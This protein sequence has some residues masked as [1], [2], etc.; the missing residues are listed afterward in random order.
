MHFVLGAFPKIVGSAIMSKSTKQESIRRKI[1]VACLGNPDRGDDAL[2]AMVAHEL[3][4]R[5]PGEVALLLCTGDTFSLIDDW[6]GYDALICVDAAAPVGTPG[7]IHRIDA[8]TDELLSNIAVTSSH[9]LSVFDAI[10]LARALECA[11]RDIVVYAVEGFQFDAGAP[12]TAAVTAAA[13]E[14]A[15]RVIA[16]VGTLLQSRPEAMLHA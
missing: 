8:R 13:R 5:L 14:V 15:R 6:A 12:V 1:L 3:S 11:P 9:A 7:C 10:N 4:G 16:E 2:G